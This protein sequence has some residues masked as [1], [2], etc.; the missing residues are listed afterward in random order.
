MH[1]YDQFLFQWLCMSVIT[2]NNSNMSDVISQS[3][4]TFIIIII[5]PHRMH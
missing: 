1:I 2:D 5:R 4:V 3:L